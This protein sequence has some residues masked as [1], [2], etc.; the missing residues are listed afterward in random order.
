MTCALGA[1]LTTCFLQLTAQDRHGVVRVSWPAVAVL[2]P[3]L[4]KRGSTAASF[5]AYVERIR[6]RN[7]ARVTEGDLDHLVFFVLQSTSYTT[8]PPIEPAL[9]AKAL[10]DSLPP[11]ERDAFLRAGTIDASRLPAPVGARIAAFVDALESASKDARL[12]Y[13]RELSN[14]T[15]G[16]DRE[17]ALAR[18]YGRAMKFVY[19]K[20]FVAARSPRPAEAV[21]ELYRRRG[22][23]TDTA[24]E[25][26][27]LVFQGLNII[28]AIEPERRIRRVLIIGPGMDL[29][30]RTALNEA[31]P[32]ASYQPWTVIDGLLAIGLARADDLEVVAADINPRVVAH[33]RRA[34]TS[35]PVLTLYTELREGDNLTMTP[36]YKEYFGQVGRALSAGEGTSA[37]VDRGHLRKTVR[38]AAAAARVVEP[39][40]LDIVTE[41]LSGLPF[42]L[43]I[44]T[45]ILPY[46]DDRELMLALSNIAAM[47]A[48]NGMF[49][50]NEPRPLIGEIGLLLGLPFEQSRVVPIATV[51]GAPPLVDTVWLHRRQGPAVR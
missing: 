29:A 45:N 51:T 34:R 18:E 42:D 47:L 16:R 36:G 2:Q 30:P 7:I 20:E 26:G 3:A 19:E 38:V 49:L 17:A 9:S 10:V 41:R 11:Q 12:A 25:A 50:H 28:K 8:L 43:A 33:L 44:A 35:P 31:G 6:T 37:T 14:A 5:D 13:F 1:V 23:S 22:L 39:V 24:V 4:E 32:P 21:A 27:Y 48:P 46:F 15:M 40:P